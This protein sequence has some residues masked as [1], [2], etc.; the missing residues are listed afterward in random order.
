VADV[1]MHTR[2]RLTLPAPP[3]DPFGEN[4]A[5]AWCERVQ[6]LGGQFEFETDSRALL[7]I[8]RAAY[9]RLP[10][11]RFADVTPRFRVRL[12]LTGSRAPRAAARFAGKPP[13]IRPLAGAGILCGAMDRANFVALTPQQRS[14][15]IVVASEML[16]YSYHIRYELLEFAVYVLAARAQGLVPLHAG[17]LGEE[18][19]GLLL[20]GPSGSGKSTLVLHG[21][22]S[23]L[24][25]LAEDSVLVAP[26]GL[27]ATGVANFVHLR[28]DS[29]RFL[30]S[31][32]R[33]ALLRRS[34]RICRRSGVAKLEIDVRRSP[35]RLAATPQRI[36][37]VVFISRR[38]AGRGPILV[39]LTASAVRERLA[40]SQRY[41]AN[42][43]GWGAFRQQMTRLP[44]YEV[45]RTSHPL[46]AV[47]ALRELLASETTPSARGSSGIALRVGPAGRSS[48]EG[49]HIEDKLRVRP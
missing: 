14:G 6:L 41:A 31:T 23:G 1:P 24:S 5:A 40:A 48:A 39:P 49:K 15:L 21:L 28:R 35:Y 3:P 42:Q 22:L 2:K 7:N 20:I 16:R 38:S 17:C 11:H 30:A 18:G 47:E 37:A 25:L 29:L 8:V 26:E 4:K 19:R 33:V 43:P 46:V 12:L 10:A 36:C 27:L 32:D 13:P 34:S 45:R 9:A 44:A